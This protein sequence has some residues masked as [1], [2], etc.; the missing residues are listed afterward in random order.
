MAAAAVEARP[1]GRL[2]VGPGKLPPPR[3]QARLDAGHEAL[4]VLLLFG[5]EAG[6]VHQAASLAKAG[7]KAASAGSPQAP[8]E[9][10][11]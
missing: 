2:I 3:R 7:P 1:A 10:G 8:A 11:S 4:E 6:V 9:A 5:I